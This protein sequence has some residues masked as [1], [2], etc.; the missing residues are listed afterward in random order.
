MYEVD[1]EVNFSDHLRNSIYKIN[2]SEKSVSLALGIEDDSGQ[3]DGPSESA[4]LCYPAGLAVRGACLYIA[5]HY[6][7][8]WLE[9]T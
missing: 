8:W 1:C 9:N 5:E 2:F 3:N 6:E 4:K 7:M